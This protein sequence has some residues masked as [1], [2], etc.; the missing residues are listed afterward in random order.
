MI[1]NLGEIEFYP[2]FDLINNLG[3]GYVMAKRKSKYGI[4][5][6]NGI[7]VIPVSYDHMIYN[8]YNN[9]FLAFNNPKWINITDNSD[10]EVY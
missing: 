2:K 7:I 1:N 8:H 6:S 10:V 5:T 9:L 3:N 4:F